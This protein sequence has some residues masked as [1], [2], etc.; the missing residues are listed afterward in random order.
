M[1]TFRRIGAGEQLF[2]GQF[3]LD[4]RGQKWRLWPR[5]ASPPRLSGCHCPDHQLILIGCD[6][7]LNGPEPEKG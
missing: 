6:C 1:P 5:P 2:E 4:T 7:D 3:F